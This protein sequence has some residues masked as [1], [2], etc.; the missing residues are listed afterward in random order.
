MFDRPERIKGRPG[1]WATKYKSGWTVFSYA[2]IVK[3]NLS[4]DQAVEL[5]GKIKLDFTCKRSGVNVVR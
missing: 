3:E 1:I 5:M 2:G 4:R